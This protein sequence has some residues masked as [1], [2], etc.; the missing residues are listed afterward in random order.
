MGELGGDAKLLATNNGRDFGVRRP[1]AAFQRRGL[2]RRGR[3]VEPARRKRRRAAALQKTGW[4]LCAA[5]GHFRGMQLRFP[6]RGFSCAL[7]AGVAMVFV[8]PALAQRRPM[9]L[10]DM[11]RLKRVSDPQLSP[12][13]SR[14]AYVVAEVLKDE[15]RTN[16]DICW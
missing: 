6:A 3:A 15:N 7:L 1:D 12:D 2:T 14:V 5:R 4:R 9:E 11:F 10:E 8:A 13:G 16:A